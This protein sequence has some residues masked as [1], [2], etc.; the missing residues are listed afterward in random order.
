MKRELQA[1]V[2][3]PLL[4][5]DAFARMGVR[6]PRGVLLHGPTGCGKTLLVLAL[7]NAASSRASFLH[8]QCPD[9]V[10]KVVGASSKNLA[11]AFEQA[12]R[13]APCLLFL[14]H[15]ESIAP[16]R[17]SDLSTEG[18][19]DRLLSTLLVEMD[20]VSSGASGSG[21]QHVVVVVAAT[22]QRSWLDPAILRPG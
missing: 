12:R 15:V 16:V 8:V 11:R 19:F 14:D 21:D 6:P 9:V 20:G 4:R 10:S 18:S 5:P 7:A 17:G 2:L 3:T 1:A 13:A 22:N